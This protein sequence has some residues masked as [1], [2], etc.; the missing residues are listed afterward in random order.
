MSQNIEVTPELLETAA[1]K[2]ETFAKEYQIEYKALYSKTDSLAETWNGSDNVAFKSQ[3]DGFKDDFDKM[4]TLMN[5]YADY[6]R[7]TAKAYRETQ[8]NVANEARK[9]KN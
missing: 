8:T 1:T 4:F 2:I 9:L 6:L 7:K 3:I 5:N